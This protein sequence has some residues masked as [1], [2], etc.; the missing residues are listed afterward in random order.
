MSPLSPLKDKEEG[1]IKIQ[2]NDKARGPGI[3]SDRD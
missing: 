3:L 2:A 1:T